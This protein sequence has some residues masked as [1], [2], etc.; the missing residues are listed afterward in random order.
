MPATP[1]WMSIGDEVAQ[2]LAARRPVVALESTL[3]AHG[4]PRPDN[5][6]TAWEAEQAVRDEGAVPATIAVWEGKPTIGLDRGQLAALAEM[7]GVMKASRRDLAV[8]IAQ[9][10]SAATTVAATSYLAH[11]ASI[12]VFATGGIGGAHREPADPFDISADLYELATT[13]VL[14]VCA[15]AKSIL[16]LPRTLEVLETLGVPVVGYRTDTLPAFVV[17]DSGLPLPARVDS[18]EEAA[19]LFAVHRAI[20]PPNGNRTGLVLVQPVAEDVALPAGEFETAVR[21]AEQDAARDG[22]RG[23]ALTPFLL[24]RLADLTGGRSLR[25]NR[26][27][28]VANA[29]LAAQV[30]V[31]SV[32]LAD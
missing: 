19:R 9:K 23:A 3:I 20:G 27:L 21:S 18:P 24:R 31:A 30:A 1:E 14:V 15:G 7:D 11:L 2:A 22:V 10:K 26:S 5:L 13:P 32:T 28:I 25:A 6:E 8:A 29:R 16:H 17:R 4:L 12:D